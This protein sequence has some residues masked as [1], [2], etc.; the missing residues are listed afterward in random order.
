MF[1]AC[2]KAEHSSKTRLAKNVDR[3]VED[4][5]VSY[6]QQVERGAKVG[7]EREVAKERGS[8]LQGGL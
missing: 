4:S 6:G 2:T 3:I 8:G 5:L 1:V 7:K